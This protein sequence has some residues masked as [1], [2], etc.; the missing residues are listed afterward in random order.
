M[1]FS[2][3][4]D[5]TNSRFLGLF[6]PQPR[7][8]GLPSLYAQQAQDRFRVESIRLAWELPHWPTRF[9]LRGFG[10]CKMSTRW[11]SLATAAGLLASTTAPA[12]ADR[13]GWGGHGG[14]WHH[15]GGW[16]GGWHRGGGGWGV[17]PAIGLGLA[18]AYSAPRLLR[19]HTTTAITTV[20]LTPTTMATRTTATTMG[21]R[22]ATGIRQTRA[23]PRAWA[24]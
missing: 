12:F 6:R 15:G 5:N 9:E 4:A 18:L 13:G 1:R 2:V 8:T 16:M 3:P 23:K 24:V 10:E 17:G 22:M 14:G 11:V 21:T 20:T 7:R 19:R